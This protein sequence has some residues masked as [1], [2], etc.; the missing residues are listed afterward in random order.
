MGTTEVISNLIIDLRKNVHFD[1]II[2]LGSGSGGP[3]PE[4]VNFIN[5][6]ENEAK[7]NLLLTDLYPNPELV[8]KINVD[9]NKYVNYHNESI[10]AT[11]LLE[12][13]KG[14]KP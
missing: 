4:V 3:M 6:K 8:E 7:L 11:N 10:N 12:A 2:Y 1:T 14:L 9:D 13:P 5:E